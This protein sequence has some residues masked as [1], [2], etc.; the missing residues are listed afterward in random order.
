MINKAYPADTSSNK[1]EER[2]LRD[3]NSRINS[4]D[5]NNEEN[6]DEENF[7][8]KSQGNISKKIELSKISKKSNDDEDDLESESED[9]QG[10]SSKIGNIMMRASAK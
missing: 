9:L 6:R 8:R 10:V 2:L 4:H 7:E 3:K 5:E 1:V